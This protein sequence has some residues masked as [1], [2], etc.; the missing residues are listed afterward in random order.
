MKLTS[1]YVKI[2]NTHLKTIDDLTIVNVKS[3]N[4]IGIDLTIKIK[5]L[6]FISYMLC[7]LCMTIK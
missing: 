3:L 6:I 7:A 4:P 1:I 5:M 2:I